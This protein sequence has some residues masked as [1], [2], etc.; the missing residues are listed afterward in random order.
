MLPA[1]YVTAFSDYKHNA[2]LL[3]FD[4]TNLFSSAQLDGTTIAD[5][6][7]YS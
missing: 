4:S 5:A 1:W 2:G 3:N 7:I 6:E